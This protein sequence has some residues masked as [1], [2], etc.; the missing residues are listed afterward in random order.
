[1]GCDP[2]TEYVPVAGIDA[3]EESLTVEPHQVKEFPET[4]VND[5]RKRERSDVYTC[6][7]KEQRSV[8]V[9]GKLAIRLDRILPPVVIF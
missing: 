9:N 3:N 5:I 8:G 4:E 7:R 2:S 6:E 1:M